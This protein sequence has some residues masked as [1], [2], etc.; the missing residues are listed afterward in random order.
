MPNIKTG[1]AINAAL[2][3]YFHANSSYHTTEKRSGGGIGGYH[4]GLQT[5]RPGA[6]TLHG[7]VNILLGG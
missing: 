5:M 4:Q 3:T 7:N 2:S 6:S 1:V